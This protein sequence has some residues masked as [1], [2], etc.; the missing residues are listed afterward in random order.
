MEI[1]SLTP[2]EKGEI[3]AL[4]YQ[5]IDADVEEFCPNFK[6]ELSPGDFLLKIGDGWEIIPT[7]D[8]TSQFRIN[9]VEMR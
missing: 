4:R 2:L 9:R 1:Y 7:I 3:Q 5:G 6:G 8:I